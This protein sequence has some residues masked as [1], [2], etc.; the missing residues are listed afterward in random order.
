MSDLVGNPKDRFSQNE[1]QMYTMWFTTQL[2][3]K[4]AN[5]TTNNTDPDPTA[6]EEQS[7]LGLHSL[8]K[9]ISLKH[10]IARVVMIRCF[11]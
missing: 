5:G 4:D 10:K 9:P 8:S 1:A 6:P 7:D 2:R 3:L 11:P